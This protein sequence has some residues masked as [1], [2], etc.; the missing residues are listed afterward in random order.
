MSVLGKFV[1]TP[2]EKK[3]Y[4]LDYSEWLETG[5][6]ISTLTYTLVMVEGVVP[7]TPVPVVVDST[8]DVPA[9]SATIFISGGDG[10]VQYKIL[11]VMTSSGSQIK[12]D[13]IILI[14]RS[15]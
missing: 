15:I 5:E 11:V 9:T 14:C 13:E 3:R 12:E 2:I 7:V 1:Q 10:G 8:I 4:S 6:T